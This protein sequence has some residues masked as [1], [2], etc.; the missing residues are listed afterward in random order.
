M[1]LLHLYLG[2]QH[3]NGAQQN[4]SRA[5]SSRDAETMAL[6]MLT[7]RPSCLSWASM[8]QRLLGAQAEARNMQGIVNTSSH[9]FSE[10]CWHSDM[11]FFCCIFPF[12][13]ASLINII[14]PEQRN[15]TKSCD[16]F[17]GHILGCFSFRCCQFWHFNLKKKTDYNQRILPNIKRYVLYSNLRNFNFLHL[18][19]CYFAFQQG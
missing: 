4:P 5:V 7:S 8:P 13:Y 6:Y 17:F 1:T 10:T 12:K 19:V 16:W 18:L 11:D 15:E 14:H 2:P 9:L 3:G